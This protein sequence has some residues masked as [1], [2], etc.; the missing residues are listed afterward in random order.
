MLHENIDFHNVLFLQSIFTWFDWAAGS[1][2]QLDPVCSRPGCIPGPYQTEPTK[3]KKY[4]ISAKNS[5]NFHIFTRR[6]FYFINWLVLINY[7]QNSDCWLHMKKTW[8]MKVYLHRV[9]LSPR[10][11]P[12]RSLAT[13][14]S[15]HH[16]FHAN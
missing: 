9:I 11:G 8:W 15:I 3:I 6:K 7:F 4:L 2:R 5:V 12:E 10:E 1:F 14:P 13:K 16:I